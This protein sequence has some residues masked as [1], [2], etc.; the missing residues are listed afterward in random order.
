LYFSD[1][2]TKYQ[3]ELL[4]DDF[5][6][7]IIKHDKFN[8]RLIE[9]LSSFRRLRTVPVHRYRSFVENLLRDPSEI[10][11]HAYEHEITDAGRSMLLAMFSL[12]GKTVG[13]ALKPAFSALHQERAER[14]GFQTRPEDFRLAL[15]EVA[16]AFI[17]PVGAHGVEVIDA[18]VLDLLNYQIRSAPENAIDIVAGAASF[19]QIERVWSF[20]KAKKGSPVLD[21][22]RDH[23]G[24][25]ADK[26]RLRML[27]NRR[28]DLGKGAVGYRGLTF[29]RR[30]TLV[31][32]IAECLASSA[33][34]A[35]IAPL[36]ARLQR[37]WETESP[38][39]C[40][41]VE[42]LRAL[43]VA[44]SIRPQER[45][46]MM[47]TIQSALLKE[48]SAG[49]RSDELRELIE[50]DVISTSTAHDP[51]LS[52]ARSGFEHYRRSLFSDELHECR[53]REQFDALIEDL[54]LFQ[55]KLGVDATALLER[56]REAK[57]D[58]EDQEDSHADHM[59]DEWKERWREER[60][61]E[62]SVSDMFG[63]L[64]GDRD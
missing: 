25:L 64:K 51:A 56:A 13:V 47:G 62:L 42:L 29:E 59:Y 36:F 20:A 40:E 35:L 43:G 37:E 33:L 11:R 41:G 7:D 48:A 10:W 12:G 9:W 19:D 26:V 16:G 2:P 28:C 53:S 23:D 27:E 50:V 3:D 52:I 17:K 38:N 6:L 5:Y 57:A 39:I 61:T 14:Y 1:L 54:E 49:C 58:F 24:R 21:A 32:E 55:D 60:A 4:R 34:A 44:R 63:S 18:S 8:P 46:R 30:L 15:R 45:A 31:V 22:L